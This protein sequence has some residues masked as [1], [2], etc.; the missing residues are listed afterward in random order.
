MATLVFTRNTTHK[1]PT[2]VLAGPGVFQLSVAGYKSGSTYDVNVTLITEYYTGPATLRIQSYQNGAWFTHREISG[3][4]PRK[5][6]PG[7]FNGDG[8][9]DYTFATVT[10]SNRE[11]M[12]IQATVK[13][14][15]FA[16]DSWNEG[17]M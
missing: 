12:R 4:I 14:Q 10:D 9:W 3:T 8:Q 1:P 7:N 15:T 5:N 6:T 16:V 17:N 2:G 11:K 13:G